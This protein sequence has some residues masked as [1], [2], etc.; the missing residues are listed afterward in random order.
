[1]LREAR[2]DE[3]VRESAERSKGLR[4]K[5]SKLSLHHAAAILENTGVKMPSCGVFSVHQR[6]AE[7]SSTRPR[8]QL[9]LAIRCPGK[10]TTNVTLRHSYSR[11]RPTWLKENA[12]IN[13]HSRVLKNVSRTVTQVVF[14]RVRSALFRRW[15]CL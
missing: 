1:M 9:L 14:P 11:G 8:D 3:S 2:K 4:E 7:R 5:Y 15:I 13:I 12:A 6:N 10:S